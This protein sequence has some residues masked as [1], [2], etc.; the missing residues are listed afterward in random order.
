MPLFNA[1][2]HHFYLQWN[3]WLISFV[4][5]GCLGYA[6][7]S[8]SD[9]DALIIQARQGNTAAATA[10]LDWQ[11]RQRLLT[12]NEVADWLQINGWAGNDNEVIRLWQ[13]YRHVMVLPDRAITAAAKSYR[14]LGQWPQSLAL[15]RMALQRSPNNDDALSGLIMTLSDAGRH[16]EALHLASTRVQRAPSA[17]HWGELAWVQNAAGLHEDAL[18]SIS[19]AIQRSPQNPQLL[20]DYSAVLANNRV[21]RPALTIGRQG[22]LPPAA[23]RQRQSDAAAEL[24]RM[25]FLPSVTERERF[26]VADRALASYETLLT[27][28][29][30]DPEAQDDYRRARIDRLGALLARY[31]MDEVVAEYEDLRRAGDIPAYARLWAASAY[32]YLRHPDKAEQLYLAVQR[33]APQEMRQP[34]EHS[35]LFYSMAENG[36][37]AQAQRQANQLSRNAPYYRHLYGSP[38]PVPNDEWLAAQQLLTQSMLLR[39]ALAQ[40]QRNI[41]RLASTAPGNQG[42]RIDLAD[43]YLMRGWPRRAE[44]EL[45]LAEGLGPRNIRLETRQGL[46]ALALQEWRQAD[47]LADD[48]MARSPEDSSVQRFERLRRVHHMAELRINA[49]R[50]IKSDSP[51]AGAHDTNI[52]TVLYSPPLA[53]NWR[54]FSG[55]AFN[56][57]EFEEGRGINRHVRGGVEFTNRDNWLEAEMSGQ[58]YGR[59]Q[60]IGARLSGWHDVSDSWRVGASAERLME[61]TPLR[62]LTNGVTAN[63]AEAYLRWRPSESREWRLA[64]AP[65]WFSDG[66]RRFEYS[67]E[68]KERLYSSSFLT[69][70]FTPSLSGSHN[71]RSDVAYYSPRND[72]ALLPALTL[73]HLLY[74]HYQTEW[75][76]EVVAGAGSY[77]QKGESHGAITTLGYGQ[78]VLWNDVLEARVMV[79]WDKRPYDGVREQNL[80]LSFDLNYRF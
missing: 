72:A 65:G 3:K 18:A 42:L 20:R 2:L 32:L 70:D 21:S 12:V 56:Q 38:V 7:A 43:I 4:S 33:D 23:L 9:Y 45:K 51:V 41:E 39:D 60:K 77:W 73:D 50:G 31:R 17:A 53:D 34:E 26:A 5:L 1:R 24:V 11:S 44:M 64:L 79:N 46:A 35:N 55:F 69:L 29:R 8:V 25:A 6:H 54:L 61:R 80:S 47:L 36:Q 15:W 28:W 30:A 19:Q 59:G 71:R 66:N 37:I 67:L 62:A 78:R 75:H 10:W 16:G 57:G 74:R 63:G 49:S 76:Q 22:E 58:N 27:R 40:A 68:A 14:N 52:D 13:R 48:V